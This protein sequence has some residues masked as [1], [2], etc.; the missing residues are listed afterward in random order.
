MLVCD[1]CKQKIEGE[2]SDVQR[3]LKN[4]ELGDYCKECS[5]KVKDYLAGTHVIISREEWKKL[6]GAKK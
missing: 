3:A 2:E 5:N 1:R 4:E 6:T